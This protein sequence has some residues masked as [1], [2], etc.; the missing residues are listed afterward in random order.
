M[1]F[2]KNDLEELVGK[3]NSL[4][5]WKEFTFDQLKLTVPDGEAELAD[6]IVWF[7]STAFIIQMKERKVESTDPAAERKWFER[8]VLKVAV[9][10]IKDSLRLFEEHG[11]ISVAN[12][13]NQ[14]RN[15]RMD[16]LENLH[17]II[18]YKPG[19]ALPRE[20][21]AI[22]IK[23]S[24]TA[25]DIHIFDQYSYNKV[26]ETLIAPEEVR[27]Y[28]D[29]RLALHALDRITS[30]L[31]EEDLLAAYITC[32]PEPNPSFRCMLDYNIR[33]QDC[34][35]LSR[36]L[37]ELADN[38]QRTP[39]DDVD[40]ARIMAE[41]ARLP[42]AAMR[43][44][45]ARMDRCLKASKDKKVLLPYR[46]FIPET[47]TLFVI[48]ALHPD[49]GIGKDEMGR[50]GGFFNTLTQLGKFYTKANTAVGVQMAVSDEMLTIDWCLVVE[51]VEF[52]ELPSALKEENIFQPLRTQ[53]LN[54]F[55]L[56]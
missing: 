27:R 36:T 8:K 47:K 35:S 5:F 29:F 24:D 33:D 48:T 7:G 15:I 6:N 18:I 40:Y 38:I 2:S 31:I 3:R 4:T 28:M 16:S 43:E 26:L 17:K 9:R 32:N 12:I 45:K 11:S 52:E 23:Q 21:L 46:V 39:E 54:S 22:K 25:G 41:F 37:N 42:N 56:R 1:E 53:S 34:V 13:R 44:I 30:D 49:I 20:C 14:R 51:E 19:A 50:R 10:Q 55:A